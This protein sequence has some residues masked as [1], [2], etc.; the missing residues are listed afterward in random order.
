MRF[1]EL[2]HPD[3]GRTAR[4]PETAVKHM[5]RNGWQQPPPPRPSRARLQRL[6]NTVAQVEVRHPVPEPPTTLQDR[7]EDLVALTNDSTEES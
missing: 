4:V 1:V 6:R 3:L 2:T 7:P 5:L